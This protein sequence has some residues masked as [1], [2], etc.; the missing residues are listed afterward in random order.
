MADRRFG[1][2]VI[3]KITMWFVWMHSGLR[4]PMNYVADK[5]LDRSPSI[6]LKCN[7]F[8]KNQPICLHFAD[9][10]IGTFFIH[11]TY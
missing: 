6:N 10:C 4:S 5:S 2:V 9:F 8:T 7:P 3:I 1:L 11:N